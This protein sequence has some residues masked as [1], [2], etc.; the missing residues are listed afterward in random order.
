[1]VLLDTH[2]I[3]PKHKIGLGVRER[4]RLR[5]YPIHVVTNKSRETNEE[6]QVAP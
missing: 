4:N 1:M 2:R 3:Y 6:E 5:G